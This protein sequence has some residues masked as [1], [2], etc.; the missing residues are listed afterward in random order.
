MGSEL[1]KA[2]PID[3]TAQVLAVHAEGLAGLGQ[4]GDGVQHALA[5]LQRRLHRVGEPAGAFFALD[6]EAVDHHGEV[7]LALLVEVDV[8][9]QIADHAVDAGAREPSLARV[10]QHFLVLALALLDQGCQQ[11]ELGALGQLG[12]LLGDLL[13]ALLAHPPAADGAVLLAHGRVEHAQIVVDLGDG[14]DGGA[15]VVGGGLLLDG[16]GGRQPADDVVM[17]LLHLPEELARVGGEALHVAALALGVERVEGERA[18]AAAG[19]AREDHELL[20]GNLQRDAL[21]VVLSGTLD[22]DGFGLHYG[23]F[24][25]EREEKTITATSATDNQPGQSPSVS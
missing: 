2:D 25:G 15:G 24:L 16:D 6:D 8:L 18:L 22:E 9:V 1:G 11:S 7:V 10:G 3:R 20:L 5:L 14:P 4:R 12:E 13:R 17:R 21:E 19:D 23:A